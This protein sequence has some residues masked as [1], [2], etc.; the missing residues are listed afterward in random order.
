[1]DLDLA[2]GAAVAG[3]FE[4]KTDEASRAALLRYG[5]ES[6]RGPRISAVGADQQAR[7]KCLLT[8]PVFALQLPPVALTLDGPQPHACEKLRSFADCLLRQQVVED[9]PADADAIDSCERDQRLGRGR[10]DAERA[11][12][13]VVDRKSTRLNSSHEWISRMPSF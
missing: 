3:E 2:V 13:P 6:L 11:Y 10:R 1:M 9:A 7:E 4:L 5:A 12:F 8:R